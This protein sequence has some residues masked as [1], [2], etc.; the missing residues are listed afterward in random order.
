MLCSECNKNPAIIFFE[1][2]DDKEKK[3]GGLCYD[4]AR[5]KGIDPLQTLKN[6][7]EFL[8]QDKVN[9]NDMTKQL[10]TIFK[11][12]AENMNL[13][14]LNNIDGAITFGI[15]EQN[16][17]DDNF[18]DEKPKIAGAAIPLGSFFSNMFGGSNGNT[19]IQNNINASTSEKNESSDRKK[20]KVD[21]KKNAKQ[22]KKKKYLD[23]FGTNL[24][25]KAQNGELDIVIGRDK[26][27]QRII[28]ILNRR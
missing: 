12:L 10:E 23:T 7:N 19:A 27:I 26:E 15:N 22:A 13:E 17:D 4:C 3:L 9:L 25:N 20:V 6:Q 24:T 2:S 18:D 5:K 14:D 1:K 11:D 28:Q 16:P 8:A 21:K